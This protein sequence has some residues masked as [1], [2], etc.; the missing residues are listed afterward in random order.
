MVEWTSGLIFCLDGDDQ[1]TEMVGKQN[2]TKKTENLKLN[3]N[4]NVGWFI[5]QSGL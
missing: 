2:K 5:S 1:W 3:K 4:D